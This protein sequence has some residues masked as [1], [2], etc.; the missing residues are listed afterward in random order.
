MKERSALKIEG[1][2]N[3]H[4]LILK[5]K[6]SFPS[7]L[8]S[9]KKDLFTGF[10]SRF[11]RSTTTVPGLGVVESQNWKCCGIMSRRLPLFLLDCSCDR[12]RPEPK[13]T[14]QEPQRAIPRG[15]TL[16]FVA[17]NRKKRNQNPKVFFFFFFFF[18]VFAE[19][20]RLPF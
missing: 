15:N 11:A 1:I 14:K 4:L 12:H 10:V 6:I 17:W 8:Q 18:C 20:P 9:W 16:R 13:P 5:Q 7:K 3:L 2:L 19:S